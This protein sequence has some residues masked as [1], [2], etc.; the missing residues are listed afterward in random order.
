MQ[1][2]LTKVTPF[3]PFCGQ[4]CETTTTGTLLKQLDINLS[5]PMLFGLGEGLGFI[6]WKMKFMDFPFI[7][8]RVKPMLLTENLARNLNLELDVRETSSLKK[9]WFNV[10]TC[11]DANKV[12][13][14]QLDS[15]HLEYFTN[16]IHFAGHF[17]AMYGYDDKDCYLVDTGQQG[18]TVKTSLESLAKARAEKGSM[19]RRNLVYLLHR[20]KTGFKLQSAIRTAIVNNAATYLNPPIKN[21]CY[22]GIEKTAGEIKKWFE[23]SEN[24]EHEFGTTA[25]L[26][27]KAGTGGALFRNMYRDFLLESSMQLE[28][29]ILTDAHQ[30]FAQIAPLW[31]EGAALFDAA[32]HTSDMKHIN[33][34]SRL[35]R[36]LSARE[37]AA[38]SLLAKLP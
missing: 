26:M 20:N 10:A 18:G 3:E 33:E 12:A 22:K 13:G 21:F 38:M 15:Y 30:Q 6:Y 29:K 32:A 35:L 25:L 24:I 19:A 17:V 37:H 23:N 8:G 28:H 16:K 11:I 2:T 1:T 5:E 31:T 9:A 4:H 7:G 14:L 36:D 34:A 27:E